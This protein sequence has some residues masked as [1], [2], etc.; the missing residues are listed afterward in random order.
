MNKIQI[1]NNKKVK[2][3]NNNNNDNTTKE[4]PQTYKLKNLDKVFYLCRNKYI[5]TRLNIFIKI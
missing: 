4:R 1:L 3:N 5:S 2:G